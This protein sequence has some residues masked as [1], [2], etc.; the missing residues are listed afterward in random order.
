MPAVVGEAVGEA[1]GEGRQRRK[2]SSENYVGGK[3]HISH[4]NTGISFCN[5]LSKVLQKLSRLGWMAKAGLEWVWFWFWCWR[6]T[7]DRQRKAFK[8]PTNKDENIHT[9]KKI[10]KKKGKNI[11]MKNCLKLRNIA[12]RW[13]HP[14]LMMPSYHWWFQRNA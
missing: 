1:V 14:K 6:K 5:A 10:D 7:Q 11:K 9:Y 3:P 8:M 12:N 4:Q 2:L 13:L